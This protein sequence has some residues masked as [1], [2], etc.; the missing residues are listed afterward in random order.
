MDKNETGSVYSNITR[1]DPSADLGLTRD[2]AAERTAAGLN[3]ASEGARSKS[4]LS[5]IRENLCSLFNFMNFALAAIVIICGAYENATFI[6][7]IIVNIF[8]G[9]IQEIRAKKKVE[10]L[11]LLTA[12]RVRVIRDG[13]V[14]ELAKEDVVLDDIVELSAGNQI[15]A[16]GVVKMGALEVDESL[17]TGESEPVLK[18][19]GDVLLSGS[20]VIS[21]NCRMRVD[22][23]GEDNYANRISSYAKKYKKP[24][25]AMMKSVNFIIKTMAVIIVPIG[26]VLFLKQYFLLG[27]EIDQA[28]V[29][30][31][32]ALIGMIPEGLI[33]L[34][35]IVLTMA[36][37][38]LSMKNTLVQETYAVEMLARV[39]M[40]CLDKTGTITE[41][42]MCVESVECMP[43]IREEEVNAAL[44]SWVGALKDNNQTYNAIKDYVEEDGRWEPI[45]TVPFSSIR[46]WSAASFRDEGTVFVGAYEYLIKDQ[47]K[48]IL[49][50]IQAYAS[51]GYRVL[52]VARACGEVAEPSDDMRLIAL[53]AIGDVVRAEAPEILKFFYEQDVDIKIISGDNALTVASVAKKAGVRGAEDYIDLKGISDE[54]VI[55]AAGKYTVFG[56]VSPEQKK[57]I[58]DTLKKK[59]HTVAMTGDGVNDVMALKEADCS[60]ALASGS[61]AA[62]CVSQIVLLDSNFRNLYDIVMEGRQSVNNLQRSAS[63]FLVKT[64]F[65]FLLSLAFI[66][67]PENYP[68]MPLHLTLISSLTVGIPSFFLAFVPNTERISGNFLYTVVKNALPG[69]VAITLNVLILTLVG[70]IIGFNNNESYTVAAVITG[71]TGFYVLFRVCQPINIW[72]GVMLGLLIAAFVGAA[73]IFDWLLKFTTITLPMAILLVCMAAITIPVYHLIKSIIAKVGDRLL[74]KVKVKSGEI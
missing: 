62:R 10:S 60:I 41:G 34:I 66:F 72:R 36:V 51:K 65:S 19:P 49:D 59:G 44:A 63:L 11:K 29:N 22:K 37:I 40:L 1:I 64:T 53:V 71:F 30:T 24:K 2:Q 6:L 18:Q 39:D 58:V 4:Y 46:K 68:F 8:I 55:A 33:L 21:G 73:I 9:T 26:A 23:V 3:N 67:I 50:K 61:D 5:I 14:V 74:N 38:K 25:S 15:C 43:G 20:F 70:A 69:G 7:I 32:A 54:E 56:R 47:K 16:D 12:P 45:S 35:S 27:A 52:A 48:D 57:I 17:L 42:R 28:V 31:V 13:V